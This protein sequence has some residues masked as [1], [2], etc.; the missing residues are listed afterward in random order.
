MCSLRLLAL[1]VRVAGFCECEE[2]GGVPVH[3]P[4]SAGQPGEDCGHQPDLREILGTGKIFFPTSKPVMRIRMKYYADPGYRTKQSL[5]IR[6]Q[7]S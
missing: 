4:Q 6:I 2:L 5:W 1:E 7:G 3:L